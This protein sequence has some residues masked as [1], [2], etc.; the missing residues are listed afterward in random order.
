[1]CDA[2]RIPE[3][4]CRPGR[5]ASE[6]GDI[7]VEAGEPGEALR[8]GRFLFLD[9][10]LTAD[11]RGTGHACA[12]GRYPQDGRMSDDGRSR[13]SARIDRDASVPHPEGAVEESQPGE[14]GK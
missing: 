3:S 4:E 9:G 7:D 2:G 1:M 13:G 14:E 8:F 6:A 12:T 10:R 11:D 5:D